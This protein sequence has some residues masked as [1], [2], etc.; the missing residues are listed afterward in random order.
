MKIKITKKLYFILYLIILI[1]YIYYKENKNIIIQVDIS[2]RKGKRGPGKFVK[3]ISEILPYNVYSC[4]FIGVSS[5]NTKI[6][7]NKANYFFLPIPKLSEK[8]FIKLVNLKKANKLLLGPIFVPKF[9]NKFPNK[10]IW[11]EKNF[12]EILRI[13]KGILVH[14]KRV[15]DYL[16]KKSNSTNLIK[17]FKI[18]RPCTNLIPKNVN[19]FKNRKIDILLFEKYGDLDRRKQGL[20]LYYL[21]NNSSYKIERI[22]YGNYTKNEMFKLANNSKFIIY[23]SFFDTGAIGLK[24]IQNFGVLSFTHQKDLVINN[25]TSFFIP[26][27]SNEYQIDLAFKKI[28]NKIKFITKKQPNTEFISKIN[29]KINNCKNSLNDLCKGLI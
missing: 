2:G 6:E 11:K 24:E 5:I 12:N 28:L 4:R 26:E 27:L 17:K 20:Q 25:K 3:G 9:W 15:R 18:I 8:H 1:E 21:F 23:F 7:R 13:V 10:N 19:S 29:Q 16:A 22:I 14:S